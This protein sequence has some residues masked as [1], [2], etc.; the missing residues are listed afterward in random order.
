[1]N[2]YDG[3]DEGAAGVDDSAE[4]EVTAED[5][6]GSIVGDGDLPAEVVA[7]ADAPAKSEEPSTDAMGDEP[8][9]MGGE[10]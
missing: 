9:T 7:D 10:T 6:G 8:A 2:L 1:M 4:T 3:A 5:L